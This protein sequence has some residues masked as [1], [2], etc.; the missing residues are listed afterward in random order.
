MA[1]VDSIAGVFSNIH[2]FQ[3]FSFEGPPQ[4]SRSHASFFFF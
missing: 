2:L 3:V 4:T 1:E